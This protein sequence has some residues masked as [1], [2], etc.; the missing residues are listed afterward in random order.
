MEDHAPDWRATLSNIFWIQS[1]IEIKDKSWYVAENKD[2][3]N[4]EGDDEVGN[5]FA[6]AASVDEHVHDNPQV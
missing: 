2:D 3:H 6:G 1:F 5:I 4:Q